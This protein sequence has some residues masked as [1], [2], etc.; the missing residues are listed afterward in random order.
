MENKPGKRPDLTSPDALGDE[1]SFENSL[2]PSTLAEFVGQ[3]K[4]KENLGVFVEAARQRREALDHCL[5]CGPP[6]LGKTTLAYIVARE[7]EVNIRVT[8]GPVLEKAGDLAGL[9]T[10]LEQGDVLFIDEIH[11]LRA[12]VEEYLYPAMEDFKLDI[13]I[14]TGPSARTVKI[15]L[16]RFTLIGATTR[17]GL[18][19]SPM[20]SRFGVVGR[21]NFYNEEELQSIVRRS[22]AILGVKIDPE[23]AGEI[24]R[25][26]R[27]TAR[28]AN[29]LL[30]RIRDFAQVRADGSITREVACRSLEMMEVDESGL[31]EMDLAILRTLVEKYEGRPVGINTL[32]VS[33]GEEPDTLEE[34]YEPFLIQRGFINRTPRG[35]EATP[36]AYRHL[37]R[38]PPGPAGRPGGDQAELFGRD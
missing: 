13:M 2:R 14:D 23:G 15:P 12:N 28:I 33:V 10:N 37:G 5:F 25:R 31:D 35:R 27:G 4:L 20:R 16:K 18:L 38:T 19:T 3:A 26:S 30:R 34:V 6:G 17:S 29:R 22:A 7:M 9:L 1:L 8:S 21:L 32:A 24:S 11:R 36:M